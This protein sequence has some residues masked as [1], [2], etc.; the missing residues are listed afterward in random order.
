ML[1][2]PVSIT[3]AFPHVPA[4]SLYGR[5]TDV[6]VDGKPRSYSDISC[7]T[8]FIGFA[9]LPATVAPAGLTAGG[10]P[11]GIQIVA[12][13]LEDRT[14]IDVARRIGEVVGGYQVPPMAQ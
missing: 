4:G 10:L 1:L 8:S 5:R 6:D 14:A 9:H 13:F 3:P 7:W 11:V 2:C 12:P